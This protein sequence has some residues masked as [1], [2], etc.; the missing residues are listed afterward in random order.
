MDTP[1]FN[2]TYKTD[3]EVLRELANFLELTY[4][5]NTKLA[6]IIYLH[7]ITDVRMDGGAMRNLKMFRKLCGDKPM[8]NVIITSSFWGSISDEIA[9]AHETEL[10]E[11]PEFWGDM[12][13]HGARV[14]RFTGDRRSALDILLSLAGGEPET[15]QLQR[16]LVDE[17]LPIGE[18]AAGCAVN[19]E[20]AALETRYREELQRIQEE[21]TEALAERDHELEAILE[22]ERA[23][24]ERRLER[25]H[26]DQ[27][28]L[29]QDRREEIRRLEMEHLVRFDKMQRDY[30]TMVA[31]HL[32][33]SGADQRQTSQQL[34]ALQGQMAELQV[35]LQQQQQQQQMTN[36]GADQSNLPTQSED[37][38]PHHRRRKMALKIGGNMLTIAASTALSVVHPGAIPV[39]IGG[40]IDLISNCTS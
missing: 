4:K 22:K 30:T 13:A 5:Q 16:E 9:E 2:D 28:L 39:A 23:K 26:S 19:E 31:Q 40:V 27:E 34:A 37:G 8:R 15:L 6:G 38:P 10:V 17:R 21:T 12:I 32:R 36:H 33:E 29:R 1:G 7:R 24:M 14:S 20:L 18:T 25:I 35:S 11:K 3:A